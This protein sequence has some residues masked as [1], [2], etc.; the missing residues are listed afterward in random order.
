M[1]GDHG[2]YRMWKTRT[3][4]IP[5]LQ[6][7]LQVGI[8]TSYPILAYTDD[9]LLVRHFY[10]AA[11]QLGPNT[12]LIGPARVLVTMDYATSEVVD[13]DFEPFNLPLFDHVTYT[14]TAQEREARRSDVVRVQ[15]LYDEM[16]ANYPEPP[17]NAVMNEFATAL[18]RVVPP[19][20][21]PYYELLLG[22]PAHAS[23]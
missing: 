22:Q 2:F 3:H 10:H 15:S 16:L 21:W 12:M 7:F 19:M 6:R 18:R 9:G 14:L 5:R 20:L 4:A 13:V 1:M 11:D 8:G 23:R 17:R